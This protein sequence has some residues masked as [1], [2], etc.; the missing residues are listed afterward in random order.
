MNSLN[1]SIGL[2]VQSG[3][4]TP[5]VVGGATWILATE[6]GGGPQPRV[7]QL[8]QEM[9]GGMFARGMVKTGISGGVAWKGI[10]RP[11]SL[12]LVLYGLAGAVASGAQSADHNGY[13]H[14]FTVGA[15]PADTP[16]FTAFRGVSTQFGEQITDARVSGL[17]MTMR[18]LNYV[19]G[20]FGLD[21]IE[22]VL[23]PD[24]SG[25]SPAPD[26]SPAF[27]A[28]EGEVKL[29]A[30]DTLSTLPVRS[31]QL[32]IGNAHE[33]DGE[34]IIGQKTP[35]DI[36]VIGRSAAL[37]AEV[38]VVDKDLYQKLMYDPLGVST[39]WLSSVFESAEVSLTF[40]TAEMIDKAATT[41]APYS[42]A[43]TASK[44]QWAA[45]PIGLRGTDIVVVQ[46][47]G[48]VAQPA[49]GSEP[50]TLTLTNAVATY[51]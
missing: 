29:V 26:T 16:Y 33:I 38:L 22:P 25:W 34:F 47:S 19:E 14:G 37:T 17:A 48:I 30:S 50:L 1:S 10:P 28:C 13:E 43:F 12:G 46:I 32:Q 20:Q 3:K 8:P 7:K 45:Q 36:D 51:A 31:A 27:V 18:S 9:G 39:A 4:G 23:V 40:K 24:I 2:A 42:L 21:G 49:A 15:D 6:T 41:P 44:T 35:R 11:D 5:A